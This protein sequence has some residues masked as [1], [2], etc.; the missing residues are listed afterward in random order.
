MPTHRHLA[1]RDADRARRRQ[2]AAVLAAVVLVVA[3]AVG[4]KGAG[5][6]ES[7]QG[8][9]PGAPSPVVAT[10]TTSAD[11]PSPSAS[12][13]T[14]A[15]K[16][17]PSPK[18][19]YRSTGRYRTVGARGPVR[20]SKGELVTYR[21]EVEEG[22]GV[23]PSGFARAVDATL[24]NPRGWTARG[25]WRFQRVAT[26]DAD[27]TIRPATPDTV[28]EQCAAAGANTHGYTSCRVGQYVVLNPGPL[29]RGG[30][31]HQGPRA[32]PAL[33][34]QPR[35]RS[36]A[37]AG[38]RA[39]PAQGQSG[40]RHGAADPLAA[41]VHCQR[42]AAVGR[43]TDDQRTTRSLTGHGR[44]PVQGW[45]AWTR[46]TRARPRGASTSSGSGAPIR[47]VP[48]RPS[49]C[50][51]TT[52]TRPSP[53]RPSPA[54]STTCRRT[55]GACADAVAGPR[56][57]GRSWPG[58]RAGCWIWSPEGRTSRTA[59]GE[60]AEAA[61]ESLST[62]PAIRLQ[63][64]QLPLASTG[65]QGELTESDVS[66]PV[67]VPVVDSLFDM[68]QLEP[69]VP[70]P[71]PHRGRNRETRRRRVTVEVTILDA[72]AVAR[73]AKEAERNTVDLGPVPDG[74]AVGPAPEEAPGSPVDTIAGL[75]WATDGQHDLM[76]AGAFRI[77]EIT[78][79]VADKSSNR[80]VITWSSTVKLTHVERLRE[81][82]SGTH[83]A[84]GALIADDLEVARNHAADPYA[85]IRWVPGIAWRPLTVAVEHLPARPRRFRSDR[86]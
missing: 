11:L 13:T 68:P 34:R 73:G 23:S 2:V 70:R 42:P 7:E 24:R 51:W 19:T 10:S 47:R 17:A 86:G 50:A 64:E 54:S 83:P 52:T 59:S 35:G 45:S 58:R 41:R 65:Q 6:A 79:E 84:D 46:T 12:T 26:A 32:L 82:A 76:E 18:H 75:I 78:S 8:E 33:P 60:A 3:I 81:L 15:T 62:T 61:F 53:P 66:L 40:S 71:S 63:W 1:P 48:S 22:A 29:A 5:A 21:I 25:H 43:R 67:A 4:L 80:G 30:P 31:A 38:P 49:G 20:G 16:A 74:E 55:T 44:S 72:A 28:D 14:S 9:A 27:L 39:L 37:R 85:P 57:R 69:R 56:S 77:M 36:R